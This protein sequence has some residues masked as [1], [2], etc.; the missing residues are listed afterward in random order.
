MLSGTALSGSVPMHATAPPAAGA[1]SPINKLKLLLLVGLYVGSLLWAYTG[2]LSVEFAYEGFTLRWPG[3]VQMAWLITLALLPALFLPYSLTRPS[4]L[5]LWWLYLSVYVSAII[6]PALSLSTPEKLLPLQLS[7]LLCMGLLIWAGSR[8]RLLTLPRVAVSPQLFWSAFWL[9]WVGCIGFVLLKGRVNSL[10]S[11]LASLWAGA[12]EYTIRD[13]YRDLLLTAGPALAYVVGQLCHAINPF[14]IAL[15]LVGRRRACLIVGILGQIIVFSLTGYKTALL[16][17]VFLGALASLGSRG[18]RSFGI[19]LTSG[20]LVA[21]LISSISD[22]ATSSVFFTHLLTRR[23]LMA[24][25]LLTGFYFEHYSQV[26]PVG[27]GVHFSHDES[28]LTPPNEIGFTYF[29]SADTA[30]NANLWAE[31]FAEAG[32]VGTFLFTVFAA[33][34]IWI[35][36]SI[37]AGSDPALA[38]LLAAMPAATLSNTAPTTVLITHGGLAAALLLYLSPLPKPAEAEEVEFE[39]VPSHSTMTVG[40]AV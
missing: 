4:A 16:S 21:V 6:V 31:G 22:R 28:V 2:I 11:N 13:T 30:A 35:Y 18:R 10:L 33:F 19:A 34:M 8:P 24:P 29:N 26:A 38:V 23:T 17:V 25:G 12:N 7:L 14:L 1:G 32:L 5:I 40:T 27:L 20:L 36:D 9:L 37:A 39:P 15:G 3:A